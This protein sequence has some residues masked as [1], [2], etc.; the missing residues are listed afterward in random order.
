MAASKWYCL[1]LCV[2][3]RLT[4]SQTP[5]PDLPP[6]TL[7][8]GG[9]LQDDGSESILNAAPSTLLLRLEGD[10]FAPDVSDATSAA[11]VAVLSAF[12][13]QQP[14]EPAGWAAVA[15]PVLATSDVTLVRRS[16][17]EIALELP[18]MPCFDLLY[19][20]VVTVRLAGAATASGRAVVAPPLRIH[21]D[22]A[23]RPPR[24]GSVRLP[25]T[26]VWRNCTHVRL[27]WRVPLDSG[28]TALAGY[29][30]EV[31]PMAHSLRDAESGL[32][33]RPDRTTEPLSLGPS[34]DDGWEGSQLIQSEAGGSAED[35]TA[36]LGPLQQGVAYHV[37]LRAYAHG[38]GCALV[39]G[40]DGATMTLHGGWRADSLFVGAGPTFGGPIHGGTL[41]RVRGACM[42]AA[43]SCGWDSR[44]DEDGSIVDAPNLGSTQVVSSSESEIHCV[45]AVAS[46]AHVARVLLYPGA[47]S[48]HTGSFFDDD[49]GSGSGGGEA[50]SGFGSG[51]GDDDAGSGR[52]LDEDGS[53]SGSS[54]SASSQGSYRYSGLTFEYFEMS[55]ID[56]QPPAG[57]MD[58][59]T[60][61]RVSLNVNGGLEL[62]RE[63]G[64]D[65]RHARC[66]FFD[67]LA[68]VTDTPLHA[69]SAEVICRTPPSVNAGPANVS[70]TLDGGHSYTAP[71]PYDQAFLYYNASLLHVQPLGGP[72]RG[73]TLTTIIGTGLAG[74]GQQQHSSSS[75]SESWCVSRSRCAEQMRCR[76]GT[77]GGRVPLERVNDSQVVC[78]SPP[79]IVRDLRDGRDMAAAVLSDARAFERRGS[80][81]LAAA[82]EVLH[83]DRISGHAWDDLGS[84]NEALTFS[85]NGEAYLQP[86]LQWTY[87][88]PPTISSLQPADGPASGGQIVT[89]RGDGFLNLAVAGKETA[90][91]KFGRQVTRVLRIVNGS[92]LV[93]DAPSAIGLRDAALSHPLPALQLDSTSRSERIEHDDGAAP[94]P[95]RGIGDDA[96][97]E[98]VGT[99]KH[100]CAVGQSAARVGGATP[101][102][103][104]KCEWDCIRLPSC[105]YIAY[106]SSLGTCDFCSSCTDR[107]DVSPAAWPSAAA[108]AIVGSDRDA[109]YFSSYQRIEPPLPILLPFSLSLNG[110]QYASPSPSLHHTS[111]LSH[112]YN[113]PFSQ[114]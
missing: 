25:P 97:F 28:G 105:R 112:T 33:A 76:F 107:T 82:V 104:Y 75:S 45:S 5:W 60:E 42:D 40:D 106:S 6:I 73:G 12:E 53:G 50:G 114:V 103:Y 88:S 69:S 18:R 49:A 9:Q 85:L 93:C 27:R 78:I 57:P 16:D 111:S 67:G 47:G 22:P 100:C 72:M 30:F 13:S 41:V 54:S 90:R 113:P 44:T 34:L 26:E 37:R 61:L 32:F 4:F 35:A 36:I 23:V 62:R 10:T 87:Y 99:G 55:A 65:P 17:T 89:V 70:V 74:G 59:G 63:M 56:V 24:W 96:T 98:L 2:L 92:F 8:L 71:L 20:E 14:H 64:M 1:L 52:R 51:S 94:R 48:S 43:T 11:G 110:Q 46:N 31:R 101:Y 3:L 102:D 84:V 79:A 91:C 83:P 7:S 15:S 39:P 19:N 86:R 66:R 81:R 95:A 58:G 68:N 21:A 77:L 29:R 108:S 38:K 109:T 80:P